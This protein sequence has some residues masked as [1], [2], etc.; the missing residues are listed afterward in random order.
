MLVAVFLQ[1]INNGT[2]NMLPALGFAWVSLFTMVLGSGRFGLD[3]LITKKLK[4]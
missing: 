4:A 3:Y 2:W 1:Q